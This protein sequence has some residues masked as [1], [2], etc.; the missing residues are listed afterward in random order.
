MEENLV[1]RF[2]NFV[3]TYALL[4]DEKTHLGSD[5]KEARYIIDHFVGK[6][7]TRKD[8]QCELVGLIITS[9]N[10]RN[11]INIFAFLQTIRRYIIH[12]SGEE[13]QVEVAFNTVLSD[14]RP[15]HILSKEELNQLRFIP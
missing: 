6:T 5:F 7:F 15:Y 2:P 14:I 1:F 4:L 11:I 13:I 10:H 12:C 3:E 8:F 9:N